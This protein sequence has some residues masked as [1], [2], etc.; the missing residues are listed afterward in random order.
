[1]R[2][3]YNYLM[4]INCDYRVLNLLTIFLY[5]EFVLNLKRRKSIVI[6]Q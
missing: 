3:D 4:K 5:F 1:M 6:A 2:F